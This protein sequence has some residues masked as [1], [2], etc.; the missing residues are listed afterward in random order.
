MIVIVTI[1]DEKPMST[2]KFSA[3]VS[4]LFKY[5]DQSMFIN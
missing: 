3:K 1:E 2:L 5:L 4:R